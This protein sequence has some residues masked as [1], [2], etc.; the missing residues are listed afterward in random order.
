MYWKMYIYVVQENVEVEI[1]PEK[2]RDTMKTGGF[3]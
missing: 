1:A 2:N 3:V